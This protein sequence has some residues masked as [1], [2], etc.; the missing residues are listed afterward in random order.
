MNILVIG[1]SVVD[2]VVFNESRTTKPGGIFYTVIS[3]L[4]QLGQGDKIFL[5]TN[6]DNQNARFFKDIYDRV[7]GEFIRKVL[8]IPWVELIVK[9]SGE[10]K[11]IYSEVPENL[12][13]PDKNLDRFDGILI[14]MISGHDISLDQIK[15]LRKNYSGLIYFDVHTL[16][17][18]VGGD[19]SR[20]FE[21]IKDFKKWARNIDI[22]QTNESELKTLSKKTEEAEIVEELISYGIKQVIVTRSDKGASVFFKYGNLLNN[23]HRDA[24]QLR[25][26]NK[27]GCGDVFGAV[28]FYNYIKNKNILWSLEQANIYAGISATYSQTGDFL[29]LKKDADERS[30]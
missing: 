10:R 2:K 7:E 28:Y 8:S 1:H 27:I 4:T 3:L 15:Q 12:S 24:L 13:L 16:S 21:E 11:E 19:L 18:G 14:N 29:N 22:L 26:I 17:R 6:I 23:Y 30:S 9:D 25:A 20:N 5:C